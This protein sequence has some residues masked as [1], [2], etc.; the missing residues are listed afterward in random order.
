M[1]GSTQSS[2]S[3]MP[4]YSPLAMSS[5][6]FMLLPYPVFSL[7]NTRT[8]SSLWAYASSMAPLLSLEPS[9][10]QMISMSRSV[11]PNM[12]SR[13]CFR[14]CSAL[15]TGTTMETFGKAHFSLPVVFH[16]FCVSS[17]SPVRSLM[18]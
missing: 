16:F 4:M 1:S 18:I 13:H 7:C 15:H 17:V 5:P 12:L 11:W 10:T 14:Y 6:R 3:T 9:L 2:D 8:R